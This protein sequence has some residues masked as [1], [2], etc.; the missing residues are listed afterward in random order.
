MAPQGDAGSL[1]QLLQRFLNDE[2]LCTSWGI[3]NR[4]RIEAEFGLTKLRNAVLDG[5]LSYVDNPSRVLTSGG[6]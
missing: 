4:A 6:I 1:S 2:S 3:K 5:I